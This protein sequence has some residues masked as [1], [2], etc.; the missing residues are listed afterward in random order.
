MKKK[1]DKQ[2]Q[3]EGTA[4]KDRQKT[5]MIGS[6]EIPECPYQLTVGGQK[7]YNA[8]CEMM[9]TAGVLHDSDAILVGDYVKLQE[10]KQA[11]YLE[12]NDGQKIVQTYANK[13]SNVAGHL[14]ALSH[15]MK[16]QRDIGSKLGLSPKDRQTIQG[17]FI[18]SGS[19]S[20]GLQ[21][22]LAVV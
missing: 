2:K 7:I 8:I 19:D 15:C 3:L 20:D 17:Y 12:M 22:F 5:M 18:S 13:S 10:F 16:Q 21:K 4:R 1:S 14:T 9:M 6:S 11:L